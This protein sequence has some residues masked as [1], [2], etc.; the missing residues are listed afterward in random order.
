M[1]LTVLGDATY[2]EL[3]RAC[4]WSDDQVL[5]WMQDALPRLLL[6]D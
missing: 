3:T 4:G 1:L 6:A 5:A 2:V